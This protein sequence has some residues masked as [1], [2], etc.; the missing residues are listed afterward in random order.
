M[1]NFFIKKGLK[2]TELIINNSLNNSEV[3]DSKAPLAMKKLE[4]EKEILERYFEKE[5]RLIPQVFSHDTKEILK[6][7]SPSIRGILSEG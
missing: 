3:K 2:N 5:I 4:I 1:K 7:I 6:K